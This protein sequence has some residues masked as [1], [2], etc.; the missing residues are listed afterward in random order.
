[1]LNKLAEFIMKRPMKII[2]VGVVVF[3]ALLVGATKVELKT[4]NDTL[5]QEDTQEY[6]DNFEYQAEFGSDPIIIMYQG[7]GNDNLLTVENIAYMNEL[8]DILSY[9]D[10]IFTINSPVSLVKEFAGMQATEFEGGLLTV[11]SGLDDV[12]TNLNGMSDMMLASASTE[13][14]DAQIA[15][16]TTAINGLITGQE[17]LGIGVT[18]L[19]SGFTNY[20][21]QIITITD[22]IQVVIDDL[23]TD[24]LLSTQVADLQTENDAL[25]ALANEMSN[26][27]TNSDA[28][29]GIADNTV[30]G[31]Q[32]ILLGLTDMVADQ[33]IMT[34]QLTTLATSLAG[35]ADGLQAMSTNLGMIY[36]NFNILEPSIPTEQSTL[37]MMV[38]EN[39]VIRPVFESFL[40]GDQNMMF[41]VVLKGGVSD[42]KIGDII[43]SINETLE[44]QGL[45]DVT[46]VSGK[47]VLDQSIKSE[48]MGSMQVMMAL[49]ALIMVVVLLI[50]FK[51]RWS[52][53]PLVIIL[54]AVIA[55]IGI[56]GWLNIGLTMVSMAVFPVLIGLGIDYSIQFQSRYTEEL[57]GGMENE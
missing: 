14:I 13:D 3:I 17:Q 11:S 50:V 52:L 32:N 22:N 21:T 16:L 40:V 31:L 44:A 15:Q 39:G 26:I 9:Y 55:T 2:L 27:A 46:I 51:V 36:S 45:E 30:L 20:S 54:F 53:L 18:S 48:M 35:V 34:V 28:L 37:D 10:E 38:Y 1:M 42:E 8:E 24:P 56:M 43:D 23:A 47:P 7:D 25:I 5:I 29:P 12:A 4:G 6:I 49:S 41:L 33:T 57:A 19:V